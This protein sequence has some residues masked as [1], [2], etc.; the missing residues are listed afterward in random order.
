MS[1]TQDLV[2]AL[3]EELKT[4]HLTYAELADQLG[5]SESSIKRMFARP[6]CR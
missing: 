6:T 1:T 5:M 4:A 2:T 3:K